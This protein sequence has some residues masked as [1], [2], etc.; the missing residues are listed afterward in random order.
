MA[1]E[2]QFKEEGFFEYHIYTLQRPS[3]IRRT[4]PADQLVSADNVPVRKELLFRAP[5]ISAR[6][7]RRGKAEGR[8]L[9]R[10]GEPAGAQSRDPLPKGSSV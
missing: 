7:A 3:T 9:R 10:D 8:S 6:T 4:R 2:P 1:A 5:T